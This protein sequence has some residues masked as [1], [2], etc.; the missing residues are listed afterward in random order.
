MTYESTGSSPNPREEAREKA[1]TIREQQK[2]LEKRNRRLTLGTIVFGSI[3]VIGIVAIVISSSVRSPSSGP[4]NMRSD[5]IVIAEEFH[6]VQ[7]GALRPGQL[8]V[9]WNLF[10]TSCEAA[11]SA[12]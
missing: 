6:A 8:P 12:S 11:T 3:A 5:G 7:T 10:R 1:R 9:P 4:L 2:Q